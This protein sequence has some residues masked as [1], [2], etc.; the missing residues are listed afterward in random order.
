MIIDQL[1]SAQQ[2]C[3]ALSDFKYNII[4]TIITSINNRLPATLSRP[5]PSA[6]ATAAQSCHHW[7]A[8][9]IIVLT[10][11]SRSF[12]FSYRETMRFLGVEHD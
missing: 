9:K 2:Y 1:I 7:D 10:M 4:I 8:H 5:T 12:R 11:I 6:Q 3:E